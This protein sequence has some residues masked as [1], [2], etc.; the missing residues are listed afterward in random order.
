MA[1]PVDFF[2]AGQWKLLTSITKP[3]EGGGTDAALS[4]DTADPTVNVP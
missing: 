2:M 1:A 4:D 3:A